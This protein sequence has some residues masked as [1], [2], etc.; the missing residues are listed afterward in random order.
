MPA[1]IAAVVSIIA[2]AGAFSAL[3]GGVV[4]GWL[5]IS[6]ALMGTF[7]ASLV[8]GVVGMAVTYGLSAVMGLNKAPDLSAYAQDRKQLIRGTAEPR[9]VIYGQ[10]QVSGPLVFARSTG[11]DLRYLHLVVPLAGHPIAGIDSVWIGDTEITVNQLDSGGNVTGG[12]LAGLVR[13]KKHLGRDTTADADLMAEVSDWTADHKLLGVAYLYL[14]LKY[15][16]DAFT[17]GLTN[18]KA[19]VRGKDDVYDP[20]TGTSGYSDNWALCVLDY[21]R[22]DFGL[23]CADDEIDWPT[24]SAA[25]NVSD[26]LVQLDA[27]ATKFQPRYRLDGSFRLDERPIDII[28]KMQSAGAGARKP[29]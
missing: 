13:I 27:A 5:G 21:L 12:D 7:A 25:A 20:R 2:S 6:G 18:I 16:M 14:R 1:A 9:Q 24:M 23:A 10:A 28:G 15:D 19:N 4:A 29:R 3:T 11:A 22:A 17:G 26:E 8:A